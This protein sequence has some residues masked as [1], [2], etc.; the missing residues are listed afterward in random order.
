LSDYCERAK[1]TPA[2]QEKPPI[3]ERSSG[4][5]ADRG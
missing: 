1:Q 5:T 4:K 3:G 2:S